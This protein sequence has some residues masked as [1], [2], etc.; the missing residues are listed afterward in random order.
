MDASYRGGVILVSIKRIFTDF[1]I[2]CEYAVALSYRMA[3]GDQMIAQMWEPHQTSAFLNAFF[4]AVYLGL[5]GTTTGIVLYLN[6]VGLMAKLGVAYVFYRTFLKICN[7]NILFLMIA[8]FLTVNAKESILLEFSNMMICFSVLL[9][10]AFFRHLQ[11]QEGQGAMFLGLSAICFC[12]EVLSYPST[13][14]LFPFLLVM[15][16]HYS[17]TRRRDMLLF[18]GICFL[19]GSIFVTTLI[20]QTGW[21]RFWE[22]VRAIVTGDST[23]QLEDFAGRLGNDIAD[24]KSAAV[25]FAVC[26]L[27]S[28]LIVR[29][30]LRK[31][32]AK[33]YYIVIF[34]TLLLAAN[35]VPVL[36]DAEN[37]QMGRVRA[38]YPA[39]YLPALFLA[40]RLKKYCGQEE[41]LAFEIGMGIGIIGCAAVLLLTNLSFITTLTYLIPGVMVSMMPIGEYMHQKSLKTR[42]VETYGMLILFVAVFLFRNIY[43]L[44][45]MNMLPNPT[46]LSVRGI[47]KDGPMA[48]LVSDYMGTCIANSN[49]ND[50]KQYVR[51]G[52]RILIV[53]SA[54]LSTIGYLYEDTEICADSTI[55]TPTYNDKLL[56]YWEMNPWK[57]PNVVVLDCWFGE[58]R[59]S[60]DEWIMKWIEE[61]F[62]SYADGRYVRIYRRE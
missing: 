34:F 33:K 4:I 39:I 19:T 44:R 21:R 5:T 28:V 53:G 40:F 56:S 6:I 58:P 8:F 30:V 59:I 2:D 3:R 46:I 9:L 1:D 31:R 35:V 7:Q 25:L 36:L 10:C 52:D 29:F 13:I 57:E 22:C 18:T 51:K 32:T 42:D 27:L 26:G 55:C 17:G 37:L 60:E 45:P 15:L 49:L 61:H 11:R 54:H 38:L 41:R 47:V 24:M 20:A 12:L 48:G 23:H 43:V 62:D 50:W 14:I 16:Y